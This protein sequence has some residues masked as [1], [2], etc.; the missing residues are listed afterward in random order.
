MT[1]HAQQTALILGPKGK[2]GRHAAQAFDARGWNTRRFDRARD[3]LMTQSQGADVIVVGWHPT[4]YEKWEAELLPMHE[5]VIA[6]AKAS[7][8]TVIMP[9]NVYNFGPNA[10]RGWDA[11]TPHLAT[12]PLAQLRIKQ[13]ALY[14][15][16]S[17]QT[18]ILRAGDFIDTESSMTWFEKF[19]TPKV[20]KGFISY[21]GDLD[22]PHSWAFLPDLARAVAMLAERRDELGQFED[23]PFAGYTLT[24]RE[25]AESL[26]RATGH[27]I[28][29]RR[30]SWLTFQLAR[31]FVPVLKGLF[32]M[33]YLWNLPHHLDEAK[34]ASICP[35]FRATPIETAFAQAIS[36]RAEVTGQL[37]A[38]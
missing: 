2:F 35:D 30:M 4:S 16:S 33:R 26:S 23:V 10:P 12:N 36:H 19:I 17:V 29:A 14:K 38:A 11:D 27:D 25:M 37:S 34:F 9:G 7:D 20:H 13:E 15:A 3:D 32:E 21:P 8:A 22:T 6:A 31:P 18:I 24:G 1:Q 28:E 5:K